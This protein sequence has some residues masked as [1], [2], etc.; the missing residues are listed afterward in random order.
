MQ[1]S[2]LVSGK[3][4]QGDKEVDSKDVLT[5]PIILY[6]CSAHWCPPC[7]KFTPQLVEYYKE[8]NANEKRVEVV[9]VTFDKQEA[10][11][12]EY[13]GEMPWLAIPYGDERIKK[14]QAK[15]EPEGIPFLVC[16]DQ[17]EKVLDDEATE[18]VMIHKGKAADEFAKLYK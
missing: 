8:W 3:L 7:R 17:N 10:Q 11:F 5:A 6:Y 12:K 15:L 18:T 13:F 4:L 16:V 9:F 2:A 14:L 1:A